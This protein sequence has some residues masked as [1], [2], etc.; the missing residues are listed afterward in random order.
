[1]K[2]G[3]K[4]F[5]GMSLKKFFR[6]STGQAGGENKEKLTVYVGVSGGVD[7][8][9]AALLLKNENYD[10]VGVHLRCWNRDGCDEPEAEDARRIADKIGIPFYVFDLEEEYKKRV[11]DYMID[12]YKRGITPNPDVM[13]NKEIKFGLFLEKALS[14]GADFVATGHYAQKREVKSKNEKGKNLPTTYYLLHTARDEQKDQ[15]Y[16]LWTLTQKQLKHIL[17]PLG[18]LIKTEVREL[19]REA[20]L[21]IAD[22]KD[23][24]GICFVGKVSLKDFIGEY[25]PKIRGNAR[26]P[27]GEILGTHDGAHFYTIGQRHGLGIGGGGEP[28][29]VAGKDI[30]TNTVVLARREDKALYRK[31]IIL[32]NTNFINPDYIL[33]FRQ[34]RTSAPAHLRWELGNEGEEVDVLARIRYRQPLVKAKLSNLSPVTYN[35]T[36]EQP[37]KFVAPGQ[38]AV[39]YNAEGELLGGGIIS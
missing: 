1:M 28:Y 8:S 31:E 9:V 11:V 39:F 38:S 36:F 15:S 21:P 26:T 30:E 12:G 23:S 10:V 35:L 18:N 2:K 24:Q 37:Q 34:R 17:F 33:N 4:V 6:N 22:K 3:R 5:A 25:L 16:F 13:C 32:T 7:S 14:M 19:A 27:T 29:Y 20:G